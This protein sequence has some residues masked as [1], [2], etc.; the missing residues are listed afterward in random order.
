MERKLKYTSILKPKIVNEETIN[1][2]DRNLN[3]DTRSYSKNVKMVMTTLRSDLFD[4]FNLSPRN[5]DYKS[6]DD[7]FLN[8][9]SLLETDD[10]V[11]SLYDFILPIENEVTKRNRIYRQLEDTSSYQLN[12]ETFWDVIPIIFIKENIVKALRS[13]TN[14]ISKEERLPKWLKM[15]GSIMCFTFLCQLASIIILENFKEYS[16]IEVQQYSGYINQ[17]LE[18]QNIAILEHLFMKLEYH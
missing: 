12:T 10:D 8:K 3:F 9:H 18:Y 6:I 11:P 14:L 1:Y 13:S 5:V 4:D 2:F 17:S 7:V 15:R 16:L